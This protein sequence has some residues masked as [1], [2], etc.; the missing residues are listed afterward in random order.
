MQNDEKTTQA[1]LIE[2]N[3]R[4]IEAKA[5]Q[6]DVQAKVDTGH[7]APKQEAGVAGAAPEGDTPVDVALAHAK[8]LD[9]QTRA[10]DVAVKEREVDL[11]DQNRDKDR[12][13]KEREAAIALAG[14]V[15]KAPS[16]GESGGQVSVTG[17]GRKAKKIIR[18]VDKGIPQ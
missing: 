16:A 3:A 11:E 8:I 13:A 12:E 10:R 17:A 2:A 1:K 7:Y 4:D 18:D 6:A 9:S 15:I 14:D 5:R